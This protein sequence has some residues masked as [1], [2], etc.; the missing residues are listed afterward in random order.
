[1]SCPRLPVLMIALL[2]T[3]TTA[4]VRGAENDVD[5][6]SAVAEE[7]NRLAEPFRFGRQVGGKDVSMEL[8]Q[9]ALMSF[10]DWCAKRSIR[11]YGCG[12]RM[13]VRLPS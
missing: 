6:N 4:I 13:V 1:M 8:H 2:A 10:I 7:L 9:P 12:R 5:S 11:V 3:A